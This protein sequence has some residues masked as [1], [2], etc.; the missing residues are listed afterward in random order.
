MRK[1]SEG[2]GGKDF[3]IALSRL[4]LLETPAAPVPT[5]ASCV[6]LLHIP[7]DK[8]F[9]V[10]PSSVRNVL[11]L[12][13]RHLRCPWLSSKWVFGALVWGT[14]AAPVPATATPQRR[15]ALC[16]LS[17]TPAVPLRTSQQ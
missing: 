16:L 14:R 1:S 10:R 8:A 6:F 11:S 5:L 4:N 15:N 3:I 17:S 7:V 13:E 2:V 12:R 9:P